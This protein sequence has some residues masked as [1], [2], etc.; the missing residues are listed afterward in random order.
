MSRTSDRK[1][2]DLAVS[3]LSQQP[4]HKVDAF[5]GDGGVVA[6]ELRSQEGVYVLA[7]A[8]RLRVRPQLELLVRTHDA[9][10][11]GHDITLT[12][13][14]VL[15][16]SEWTAAVQLRVLDVQRR[17]SERVTPRTALEELALVHVMGARGIA[18]GEEFDV[19]L[20][21]LSA[22]GVAFVTDRTFHIG[23]SIAIMATIGS[24]VLRLQARVLQTSLSHYGRQRV[25][26]EILQITDEDRRRISALTC[27]RPHTGTAEQRLRRTA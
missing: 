12:V 25:G 14:D 4:S 11:G 24:R 5:S 27:E 13:A 17:Q 8:P 18:Q 1:L 21:D 20:A 7:E 3:I 2:T 22:S 10:G 16:H 9:T 15:R 26:C 6:L 23:D 19:R